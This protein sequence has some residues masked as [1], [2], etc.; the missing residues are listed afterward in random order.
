MEKF[1]VVII[2]P[3]ESFEL[4]MYC[5]PNAGDTLSI[6]IEN[7]RVEFTV[8]KITHFMSTNNFDYHVITIRVH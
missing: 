2:T 7:S 6:Q 3:L 4:K 1:P 8:D 5:L